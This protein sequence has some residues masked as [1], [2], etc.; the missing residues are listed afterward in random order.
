MDRFPGREVDTVKADD[1]VAGMQ[2]MCDA[3]GGLEYLV[4]GVI[5]KRIPSTSAVKLP[6]STRLV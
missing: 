1:F 2:H 6:I 3:Q 5:K 4:Q